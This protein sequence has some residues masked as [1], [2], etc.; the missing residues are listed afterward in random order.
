MLKK[1]PNRW[2]RNKNTRKGLGLEKWWAEKKLE[3]AKG[4]DAAASSYKIL[5][6]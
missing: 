6:M 1:N 4:R 2:E 5:E 3:E